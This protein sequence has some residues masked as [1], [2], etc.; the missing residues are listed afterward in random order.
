MEEREKERVEALKRY[1]IL[2]TS[3]DTAFDRIT[4]LVTEL[5]NVPVA[6]ISLVDADRIWFKS[7]YGVE[8][9]EVKRRPG[10]C[11][12]VIVQDELYVVEHASKDPGFIGHLA[13]EGEGIEFYAGVPLTTH[14]GYSIGVLSAMDMKPGSLS[15]KGAGALRKL[16]QVVMDE[17]ELHLEAK[18]L[19]KVNE[20]LEKKTTYDSMTGVLNRDAVLSALYK[21]MALSDRED[22]AL[23]VLIIDIDHFKQVNDEHGHIVGDEVIRE[24]AKRLDRYTRESDDFGRLSGEEFMLLAYPSD[25]K[26]AEEIADRLRAVI[27][28]E[29]ISVSNEAGRLDINVTI[30][31]GIFSNEADHLLKARYIMHKADEAL[32]ES[33][34]EGRNR[35]TVWS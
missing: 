32:F 34:R 13:A 9:E 27:A 7:T 26:E 2:D 20:K 29:P 28:E 14:D 16:A 15:E 11:D 18:R 19:E 8:I 30:S 23:S 17:I 31:I 5:V 33:K 35:I 12:R 24:V 22:E 3:P 6:M 10:L 21:K 1:D 25:K 4:E